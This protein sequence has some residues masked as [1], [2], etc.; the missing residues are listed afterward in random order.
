MLILLLFRIVLRVRF[1][2]LKKKHVH[3]Y[4]FGWIF[5]S[6][7]FAIAQEKKYHLPILR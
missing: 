2:P 4:N 6:V 5:Y 3:I 1:R 7:T